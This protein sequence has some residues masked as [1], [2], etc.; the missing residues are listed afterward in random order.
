MAVT[1]LGLGSNLGAREQYLRNAVSGLQRHGIEVV[2]SASVYET[3][4]KGL[5]ASSW[6]LNTVV[7]ANTDVQV[8][9][10]LRICFSIEHENGRV[11]DG[12]RAAR[13]LDIDILFF[14]SQIID[15]PD[16]R[17]PHPRLRE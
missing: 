3:Q 14:D 2:R 4:P 8:R 16:L 13:T 5:D 15:E 1:F 10:L 6:F 12:T 7:Q 11:R 9:E 17:I